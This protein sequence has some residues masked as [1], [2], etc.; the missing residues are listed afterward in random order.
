MCSSDL[1]I[2]IAVGARPSISILA[3]ESMK[4]INAQSVITD[5]VIE[6]TAKKVVEELKFGTNS[7]GSQEYRE[8]LAYVYVKRG[9]KEVTAK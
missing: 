7:R 5:E 2:K 3:V 8:Q 4:F 9:L 6:E 1:Q